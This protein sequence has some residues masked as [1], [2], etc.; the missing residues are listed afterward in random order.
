MC[1]VV[2]LT[3]PWADE[4]QWLLAHSKGNKFP[5][6]VLKLAF[7]AIVYH[8]WLERN[9]RCFNNLFL[10]YQEIV[11]KVRLDVTGKLASSN[12]SQRCEQHHSPCVNW[13][14]TMD[15]RM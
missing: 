8:V 7:A 12:N 9:R 13:G 11:H 10:P 2:R 15:D 3:L 14:I 5:A 4:I 6:T 1:N